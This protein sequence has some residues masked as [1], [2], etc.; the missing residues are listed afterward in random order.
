MNKYGYK[1][2]RRMNMYDLRTLCIE[3][4]WYTCGDVSDYDNLLVMAQSCTN[5]TCDFLVE[6][7]T[8]ILSHSDS[9]VEHITDIMCALASICYSYFYEV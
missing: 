6:L 8:D 3:R 1:E 4:N 5:V 7:A 9:S 2:V